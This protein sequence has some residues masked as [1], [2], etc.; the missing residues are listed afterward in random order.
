MF[1]EKKSCLTFVKYVQKIAIKRD[2]KERFFIPFRTT[3]MKCQFKGKITRIMMKRKKCFFYSIVLN[4][5]LKGMF[6]VA[7]LNVYH[8][9]FSVFIPSMVV[10]KFCSL[11]VFQ[12]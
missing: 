10:I 1:Q 9:R 6:E 3:E 12:F 8:I 4:V 11:F 5:I 7:D 2:I